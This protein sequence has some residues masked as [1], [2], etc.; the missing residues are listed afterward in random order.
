MQPE[1]WR[2]IEALY[3]AAR[4]LKGQERAVF[5]K[6]AC[7][8]DA[9]LQQE[10]ESLLASGDEAESFIETPAL[11]Y[12]AQ[13]LAQAKE[14]VASGEQVDVWVGRTVSHYLVRAKLGGGGMGVVYKAEDS[15]LHRFVALKFLPEELSKDRQ[16]LERFR[17]E[18]RA[19]SALN[20]PNICTIYDIDQHEGQPF[21]AMELLEGQTLKERLAGKPLKTNELLN[22]AIQIADALDTAHS[23]GII[24]RDI[25]PA[26]IF[27]TQRGQAKILDFGLAK[28]APKAGGVGAAGSASALPTTSVEPEPLTSSGAVMGTV[29]YMSPE[30]ARGED[31]DARTDLFS[32][33][34]VLYE[35]ATGH[36]AFPSGTSALI[37]EAI[38]NRA[39]TSPV[40]LNPE[41]P[42][43][44][45]RIINKALEK[46]RETRYQTASDLRADLKRLKRDTE[47]GR[48][49]AVPAD[50]AGAFRFPKDEEL[51]RGSSQEPSSDSVIAASLLKRHKLTMGL[52]I[53]SLALL[54]G[55]LGLAIYK[56][57][58]RKSE[59]NFQNMKIVRITESGKAT[60]VAVSPDGQ[61]VVYVLQEGEKHG[62]NVRQVAT[63]SDVQVLSP[64]VMNF[65]GLT[66]SPD[67]NYIYFTRSDKSNPNYSYLWQ[68]PALGGTPRQLVRDIDTPIAFSPDGR[69]FAFLRGVPDK[70]EFQVLVAGVEGGG[71]RLLASLSAAVS[72]GTDWSPDGK[73]VAVTT[74]VGTKVLHGTISNVSVSDGRVRELY[75]TP[76]WLGP[77]RW[78]ADGSGLLV[79]AWDPALGW[80]AQLW[81]I[82]FPGGEARRFTNDLT[83]YRSALGGGS[84]YRSPLDMTR[85][86]KTLATIETT[87][88]A[89]LWVAPAGDAG[90]ARQITTGA[91]A[92]N[93]LA[94]LA[95]GVIVYADY[96]EDLFSVQ[97]DGSKRTS[98]APGQYAN[99][100]PATCGDGRFIVFQAYRNERM[101]VWRMDPDGSNPVQL[102]DET[103]ASNPECSPDGKSVLYARANDATAWRVPIQGGAPSQVVVPNKAGGTPRISPDS[104]LLAYL[105]MPA[106]VSSP[107]VLTVIPFGGGSPL[108]RFDWPMGAT[109]MRWAPD[110]KALDYLLTRGG[111]TNIWR[112]A[113]AGGSP[114]QITN[115]K[116][117]LIF[118][119]DWSRD[120][121][122]LALERGT[123]SSDVVLISNFQ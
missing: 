71:E 38:L 94:W 100:N 105:P 9:G 41:C 13:E 2:Q 70:G 6:K 44:L 108:Y 111:A 89:D 68:M 29:A 66:Y 42:A 8:H 7:A 104:R 83:D 114:K 17:R 48:S 103:F 19:A 79:T 120:G 23:K 106:A 56:L 52:F 18:A 5:V 21:L 75:S 43:E 11:D 88:A 82:S 1:R 98:L 90:R 121:K 60:D 51:R 59:L 86:R 118:F 32:F 62:L 93:G 73:T 87:T 54:L 97:D 10:L 30:Q 81:Q 27:V 4:A 122:Q 55:G 61:Y 24:H 95:S 78:L 49:A 67:G 25:K 119:F 76:K 102:T 109:R 96:D 33:G 85:D 115:F 92:C 113:L 80:R 14:N 65:K 77:P 123:I 22:L 84:D 47:S 63:G 110:G 117:D 28:L 12:A 45:E 36:P 50:V 116:S 34:V 35:M 37:F 91:R 64:D 39:P 112:Q 53:A 74:N 15:K 16:A 26:N 57:S 46:D 107:T 3:D 72:Y 58:V 99:E 31:L 40:R 101:N 69:Q 20:H